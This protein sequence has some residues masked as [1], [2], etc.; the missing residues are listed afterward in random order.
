MSSAADLTAASWEVFS[1]L[2]DQALELPVERRLAWLDTLSAEHEPLKS[3]LR[4]VLERSSGMETGQWL[5]TLPH[6][7]GAPVLADESE[8]QPDALV[9]PYRLLRELG[10]GGMG[11][12]W[13]A[14]R[15]DGTL[16]RQV[17]LKLP[18]AVW[19]AGLAQRM[20][21]E[22]DILAALAHPH[23]ARLYDA[24]TDAQGRPF[25]A[26]EYV[27]GQPIDVYCRER[28]LNV[29][30]RLQLL[31]QVA[32]AVAFAHSRLVVHRDLKPSNILVTADGQVR[33]LDFGIA[34]L[35]EGD[36]AQETQL[37]QFAGRALTLDYASPEHIR[38][39]P[40]GT[41]SDVYSLG[42][43]S[44]EL[45]AGAKPYK[46]KRQTAAQL[47]EAIAAIDAP[48]A[49]AT[50][51]EAATKRELKGDLDAI[52]NKALKKSPHERYATVDALGLDI[53]RHLAG[54]R[55]VARPDSLAYLIT[56]FARRY[57]T[58]LVA[59][60]ITVAA[61]GLAIGVGA[62][63]LVILAL[64][65]GLGAALWQA[66]RASLQAD[67]AREQTRIAQNEAKT[68]EAVQ[69]FLEGIFRANSADQ[70]DPLV[71]RQRTAKELL[72]EGAQRI[73]RELYDVPLAKLR[74]LKALGHMYEDM[75]DPAQ[76]LP[77]DERRIETAIRALGAGS[78][79]ELHAR[80]DR[81]SRLVH[82]ERIEEAK[83]ELERARVILEA[84]DDHSDDARIAFWMWS[85]RVHQYAQDTVRG[86]DATDKALQLLRRQPPSVFRVTTLE[87]R[88]ALLNF[89][90]RSTE[91]LEAANEGLALV[92]AQ[93]RF[94]RSMK[95]ELHLRAAQAHAHLNDFAAAERAFRE[96]IADGDALQGSTSDAAASA[97]AWCGRVLL[98]GSRV[99]AAG[100]FFREAAAIVVARAEQHPVHFGLAVLSEATMAYRRLGWLAEA[101]LLVERCEAMAPE[102]AENRVG[103]ARFMVNRAALAVEVGD[104]A[105]AGDG[106]DRAKA[107]IDEHGLA[108]HALN[109]NEYGPARVHLCAERGEGDLAMQ[110]LRAWE[111]STGSTGEP[112]ADD[113]VALQTWSVALLATGE[114]R[115]AVV[116]CERGLDALQNDPR[117]ASAAEAEASLLALLGRACLALGEA[118]RAVETLRQAE[119]LHAHLYDAER[120]PSLARVQVA[121]GQA[122]LATGDRT[123]AQQMMQRAVAIHARHKRLGPQ[124]TEP[125]RALEAALASAV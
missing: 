14:E 101:D 37:T 118:G 79:E 125:L 80:A 123:G 18:R 13:L 7:D 124:Y 84:R 95:S 27:E 62:T 32:Q 52:L 51:T 69:N 26:L 58:P 71:A 78:S 39:E 57:R 82:L 53:Q 116:L 46:L 120:A 19:S 34:K 38:G 55:V 35:M 16:K 31:L 28:A 112:A 97:R 12:V 106:L 8:L 25:L 44:Y 30:R 93:P 68:A 103:A 63:A 70:D 76:A 89:A 81:V 48:L 24:G 122:L 65:L 61:F 40:L 92:A 111:A 86:L 85:G 11:A 108:G 49:S 90:R 98:Q 66:R 102:Q 100:S 96:A 21:R 15:A 107:M 36:L 43:V 94:G 109:R 4:T 91:A 114:A 17:A 83:L 22:R 9:G 6:T 42:V 47:E 67:R 119:A 41:A 99:R 10:V 56:R 74:V 3:A 105:S 5:N 23:I 54:H 29:K 117:R 59:A 121:L 60:A 115:Q 1:R 50:A 20:A 104:F 87:M 45:L 72:D 2:L 88:A 73:E 33:L 77:M 110:A 75:E 113:H 64:L